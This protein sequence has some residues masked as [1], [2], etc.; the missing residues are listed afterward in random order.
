M[1]EQIPFQEV[2]YKLKK[3]LGTKNDLVLWPGDKNTTLEKVTVGCFPPGE[4]LLVPIMGEDGD[5]WAS[6]A[7][8][9]GFEVIRLGSEWGETIR[10][11]DLE[12]LLRN[13]NE[14]SVKGILLTAHETSTG[15]V[16][17]VE[18]IAKK[19]REKGI[20]CIVSAWD[21][22]GAI[23]LAM[24]DWNVDLLVTEVLEE[25]CLVSAGPKAWRCLQKIDDLK[26][27]PGEQNRSKD[28]LSLR[29]LDS[30]GRILEV[31]LPKEYEKIKKTIRAGIQTMGLELLVKGDEI[32]SPVFTTVRLPGGVD[33]DR[34]LD[35]IAEQGVGGVSRLKRK[36]NQIIRVDHRECRNLE[37]I[38][39]LCRALGIAVSNQGIP[40][41]IQEGINRA[42]EVYYSE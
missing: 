16:V 9:A 19:C 37:L 7:E 26:R 29:L 33:V 24:D 36:E 11:E 31:N 10:G 15:V 6:V 41:Q 27:S 3:A 8:H 20:A 5:Q 42:Q 14:K 39:S 40:L 2:V 4:T 35:G 12:L 34:V 25:V 23:G 21:I 17:D 18:P 38:L 1:D 30:I 22:L 28:Q 13:M 32:A